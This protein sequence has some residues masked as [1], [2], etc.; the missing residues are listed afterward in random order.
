MDDGWRTNKV[1]LK[2]PRPNIT[3]MK[4][5]SRT[6]T[7]VDTSRTK[8]LLL[9]C[10]FFFSSERFAAILEGDSLIVADCFLILFVDFTVASTVIL[11]FFVMHIRYMLGKYNHALH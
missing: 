8:T 1:L 6:S 11:G 3:N 7:S 9:S 10:F 2:H 5:F 4:D